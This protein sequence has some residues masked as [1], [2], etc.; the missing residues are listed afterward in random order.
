MG[1][2]DINENRTLDLETDYFSGL[3]ENRLSKWIFIVAIIFI[4]PINILLLYSVTWYDVLTPICLVSSWILGV[5]NL[6]LLNF[7]NFFK[8]HILTDTLLGYVIS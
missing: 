3:Y 2:F 1:H 5:P 7:G 6:Y 4:L 8:N